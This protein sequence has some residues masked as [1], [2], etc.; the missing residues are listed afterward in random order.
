MECSLGISNFLE[1]ISIMVQSDTLPLQTALLQRGG[2]YLSFLPLPSF[3]LL[4]LQARILV[5]VA[6]P[7]PGNLAWPWDWTLVFC[8][9][10]S[11]HCMSLHGIP[12]SWAELQKKKKINGFYY[13]IL[14]PLF[15]LPNSQVLLVAISNTSQPVFPPFPDSAVTF[16]FK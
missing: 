4:I 9:A 2:I 3:P 11:L 7:S 1:E 14:F 12:S 10:G 8:I 16:F 13:V 6:I 5:W 15:F